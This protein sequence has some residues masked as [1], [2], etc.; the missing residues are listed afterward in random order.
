MTHTFRRIRILMLTVIQYLFQLVN[1][2]FALGIE[3]RK[4]HCDEE[5]ENLVI[6]RQKIV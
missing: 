3:L 1:I 6:I 2:I 4:I 5:K